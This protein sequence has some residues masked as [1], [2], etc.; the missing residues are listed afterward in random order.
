MPRKRSAYTIASA[1]IGNR[2]GPGRLRRI[3]IASAA[4]RITTS[5]M[6]K[7]FTF[8]RNAWTISPKESTKMCRLKNACRTAGQPA[9][10]TTATTTRVTKTAV[11]ASAIATP[12]AP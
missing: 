3:A 2:T 4:T 7:I 8:S 6:Q 10:L 1:R 9:E 5:A 12:R 11:L